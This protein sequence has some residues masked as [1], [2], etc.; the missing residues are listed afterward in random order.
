MIR[1]QFIKTPLMLSLSFGILMGISWPPLPLFILSWI[2]LLPVFQLFRIGL[3]E[4]KSVFWVGLYLFWGVMLWNGL[5]TWWVWHASGGGAIAMIIANSLLMTSVL[6][7]IYGT[8]KHLPKS[9]FMPFLFLWPAFEYFHFSWDIAYPWLTLGHALS[10]FP[11]IIQ[12]YSYTGVAGGSVWIIGINI[13]LFK[14]ATTSGYSVRYPAIIIVLP[15]V[16]SLILLGSDPKV[17]TEEEGGTEVVVVQPN[18]DPYGTKFKMDPL[19]QAQELIA[20]L[21]PH[22]DTHTRFVV[23]PETAF[24]GSFDVA[25]WQAVPKVQLLRQFLRDFPK[26]SVIVGM[27]TYEMY[28]LEGE[29]CGSK[30]TYTA[31]QTDDSCLWY[32]AYNTAG[33]FTLTGSPVFYHKARLVP[34]VEKMPYPKYLRFLEP[35]AIDLDGTT[36]SLGSSKEPIIME[37]EEGV[38]TAA[39]ICYESIFGSYVAQFASKGTGFLTIITNDGW[40]GNT[41]GYKQHLYYGSLRAIETRQYIARAAN[42]GISCFIDPKGR[43]LQ[44]TSWWEPAVIKRKISVQS[45]SPTFYVQYGDLIYKTCAFLGIFM[46]LGAF[47]K[48]IT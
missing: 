3:K 15:L 37:S 16:F 26:L 42:T 19:E 40:W 12:W 18:Q 41:P 13:A 6:M 47:V 8:Q 31:R 20:M 7:L 9:G 21:R 28:W 29:E 1:A 46:V 14:W 38:K 11:S 35:L 44:A 5:T 24:T 33:F 17:N 4:G 32:D 34:G 23:L 39:L 10:M 48:K 36:G 43:I 45:S 2:G 25:E 22:I 27:E 30:P